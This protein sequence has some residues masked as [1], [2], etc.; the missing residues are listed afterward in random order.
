MTMIEALNEE[1]LKSESE[2]T[3]L[4][5]D[6]AK[7]E[8]AKTIYKLDDKSSLGEIVTLTGVLSVI[9]GLEHL[10]VAKSNFIIYKSIK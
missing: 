8:K 3:V 6:S 1:T 7:V 5:V 9:S 10:V 4:P 2:I